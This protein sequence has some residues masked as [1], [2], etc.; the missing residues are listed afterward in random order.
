MNYSMYAQNF[1][2]VTDELMKTAVY[3]TSQAQITGKSR[4]Q[5]IEASLRE[6]GI[7]VCLKYVIL[8]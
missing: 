3:A 5:T 8:N 7:G 2:G 1:Q 4:L 6:I